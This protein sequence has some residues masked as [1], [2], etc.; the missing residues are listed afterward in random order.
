MKN[1]P[2]G[3]GDPRRWVEAVDL[4]DEARNQM[5]ANLQWVT[6]ISITASLLTSVVYMFLIPRP[7]T[8]FLLWSLSLFLSG[9]VWLVLLNRRGVAVGVAPNLPVVDG[10][11]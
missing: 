3:W 11:R 6:L 1:L 2:G 9:V 7:H 10:D 5:A 8:V 4:G